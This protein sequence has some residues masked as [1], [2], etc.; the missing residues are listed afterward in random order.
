MK[1]IFHT[2]VEI[3]FDQLYFWI[4]NNYAEGQ[5]VCQI[6]STGTLR[7]YYTLYFTVYIPI[8]ALTFY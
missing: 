2:L 6:D 7:K 4:S 8:Y 3:F 5:N 1:G